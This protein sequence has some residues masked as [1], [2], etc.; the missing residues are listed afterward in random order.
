[1]IGHAVAWPK[2]ARSRAPQR[3]S[4]RSPTRFVSLFPPSADSRWK[5]YEYCTKIGR[6][7]SY[8]YTHP[9]P[10]ISG[11][12]LI[13]YTTPFAGG[14]SP[15]VCCHTHGPYSPPTLD[16]RAG[17]PDCN[18]HHQS[19][20]IRPAKPGGHNYSLDGRHITGVVPSGTLFCNGC[21]DLL[22]TYRGYVSRPAVQCIAAGAI[23]VC[24]TVPG[25]KKQPDR[26]CGGTPNRA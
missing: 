12:R 7:Q 10:P 24:P 14:K 22:D 26:T 4:G 5:L 16:A 9:T 19:S 18:P 20:Y 17:W 3:P 25:K 2:I 21:P 8:G 13:A 6:L 11:R 1:M 15:S 23:Y